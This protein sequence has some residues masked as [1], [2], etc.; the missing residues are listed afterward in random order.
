VARILSLLAVLAVLPYLRSVTLPFIS[1]DYLVL[2]QAREWGPVSGWPAMAQDV[3]YRCRAT[4]I[5]LA[6]WVGLVSGMNPAGYAAAGIILH[7]L[8][9]WLVAALGRWKAIGW[10][11]SVPAAAFFA[12]HEIKQE[13]VIWMASWHELLVFFFCLVSLH[14]FLRWMETGRAGWYAAALTGYALALVSKES[15]VVLVG[16]LGL[17]MIVDQ[18]PLRMAVLSILP[19]GGMALWYAVLIFRAESGAHL[20][21]GDGTF[22][23]GWHFVTV[24][25]VSTGRL[26]W[27]WGAAAAA[28]LVA[29][30]RRESWRWLALGCAWSMIGLL[31]YCF[32]TYMPRVPSRHNY[33]ASLGVALVA[34]AAW[35]AL[36]QRTAGTRW[37]WVP[38]AVAAAVILHNSGYV[39]RVKHPQYVRRAQPTETLIRYARE[40]AEPFALACFPY[41]NEVAAAALQVSA[42]RPVESVSLPGDAPLPGAPRV[43]IREDGRL[44]FDSE[45]SRRAK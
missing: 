11:V 5:V 24:L 31:P 33:L 17:V 3:L 41:Y 15:A 19:F 25:M 43:C 10:L 30:Q 35:L 16:W 37:R 32:L 13:A 42:P 29:L 34:G 7:I 4:S 12:L 20:H 14:A 21:L 28:V 26:F 6:Y 40:Q 1:D 23:W 38:A 36:R 45:D 8:N 22:A 39:W 2:L 18:R 27:F 44:E 9:T